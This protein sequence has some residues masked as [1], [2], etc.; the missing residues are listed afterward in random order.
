MRICVHVHIGGAAGVDFFHI[1]SFGNIWVLTESRIP[2]KLVKAGMRIVEHPMG[3]HEQ[4]LQ[5]RVYCLLLVLSM[6]EDRFYRVVRKHARTDTA[7]ATRV[8]IGTIP[9]VLPKTNCV[10]ITSSYPIGSVWQEIPQC[11][12]IAGK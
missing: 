12:Q 10:Q 1:L 4:T 11:T 5:T 9:R 6:A 3:A 8:C 7:L 2:L